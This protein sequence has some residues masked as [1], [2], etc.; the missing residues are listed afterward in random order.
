MPGDS[1]NVVDSTALPT[2]TLVSPYPPCPDPCNAVAKPIVDSSSTV[3]V[4]LGLKKIDRSGITREHVIEKKV[5]TD[6]ETYQ[7]KGQCN[8]NFLSFALLSIRGEV[9]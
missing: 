5:L 2:A 7:K 1:G 3:Y 9:K 8:D 6:N 4:I